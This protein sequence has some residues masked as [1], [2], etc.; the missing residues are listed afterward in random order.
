MRSSKGLRAA[1]LLAGIACG[2]DASAAPAPSRMPKPVV[3][4]GRIE[5]AV[6]AAMERTGARGLAVAIV[7]K[8]R[9]VYIAAHGHRNAKGDP[10][11]LGTVMYGASVTKAVFAYTVMQLADE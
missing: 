5:G 8:G 4:V 1:V 10:L 6:K 11:E 3:D 9:P 2:I 7:E